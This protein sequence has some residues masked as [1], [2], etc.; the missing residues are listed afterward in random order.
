M[1][2]KTLE[3]EKS[4]MRKKFVHSGCSKGGGCGSTSIPITSAS[5]SKAHMRMNVTARSLLGLREVEHSNT[6]MGKNCLSR[7]LSH[8]HSHGHNLYD[9]RGNGATAFAFM[10]PSTSFDRVRVPGDSIQMRNH[11]QSYKSGRN[12]YESEM[13]DASVNQRVNHTTTSIDDN[14]DGSTQKS[15]AGADVFSSPLERMRQI[16]LG[17]VGVV[18]EYEGVIVESCFDVELAAWKTLAVE[19]QVGS[20]PSAFALKRAQGM[21]PEHI[22]S[23]V[24]CWTRNPTRIQEIVLRFEQL[25][26]DAIDP[27][28]Q[29]LMDGARTILRSLYNTGDVAFAVVSSSRAE[30]VRAGLFSNGI[31]DYFRN[32]QMPPGRSLSAASDKRNDCIAL[33]AGDDI[34]RGRPDP[35]AYIAASSRIQR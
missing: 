10:R 23:Q 17:W 22:I 35:E 24:L 30:R 3:L 34:L 18:M 27:K 8:C 28:E 29:K 12:E 6:S 31:E 26:S 16:G 15:V 11:Q 1:R 21:L 19:L 13:S 32:Q 7:S 4:I 20:D 14:I 2:E 5:Y 9:E 33:V 25:V